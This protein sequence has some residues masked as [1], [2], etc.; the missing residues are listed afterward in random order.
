MNVPRQWNY[1]NTT[2]IGKRFS[3]R[4]VNYKPYSFSAHRCYSIR[5]SRPPL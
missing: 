2:L 1:L 4:V 3:L 5:P